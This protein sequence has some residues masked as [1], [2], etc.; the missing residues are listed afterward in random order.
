[1]EKKETNFLAVI[2]W[3]LFIAAVIWGVKRVLEEIVDFFS[4]LTYEEFSAPD[5]VDDYDF[6]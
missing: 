2:G 4:H 1:M 6:E 3:I 5:Y